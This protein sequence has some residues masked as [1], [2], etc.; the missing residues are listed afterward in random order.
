MCREKN[1]Y[2]NSINRKKKKIALVKTDISTRIRK[3]LKNQRTRHVGYKTKQTI[4]DVRRD[5]IGPE[6]AI[7][8]FPCLQHVYIIR[9]QSIIGSPSFIPM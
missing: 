9:V 4:I 8:H 1:A 6:V 3:Q 2:N 7:D 5:F